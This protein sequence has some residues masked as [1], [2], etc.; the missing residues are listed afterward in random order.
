MQQFRPEYPRPELKRDNWL[1]LNG[2]WQFEIDYCCNGVTTDNVDLWRKDEN[3]F[4][5]I[6]SRDLNSK[7][8]VPFCPES[9]LSGVQHTDFFGACWYKN[10][11]KIPADWTGRILLHFEASFYNTIVSVNGTIVGSHA[12]GYTPFSFDITDCIKDGVAD[13]VVHCSGDARNPKQPS[14]KQSAVRSSFGCFYTRSTGI[15]QT[16][17]LENVPE[18]YLKK[19]KFTPDIDNSQLHVE[20]D[21][22]KSGKKSVELA[23][24]FAG[25]PVVSK[26]VV[27]DGVRGMAC[28]DIKDAKLWSVDEPNL[29]DLEIKTIA[30]GVVDKVDTY[31]GMR[32]VTWSDGEMRINGKKVFQRLVLDQGYY[33]DG[34]YTA[35]TLDDLK[36]DIEISQ[37]VG[38]NGARLHQKVFERNFLYFADKMGYI[39]W[40]EYAS[41]GFDYTKEENTNDYI[42]E[43]LESVDRDYNHPAIIGWIPMNENWEIKKNFQSNSLVK[44]VYEA[45]KVAD[46]TR[47]VIDA[48]WN[49]HVVTDVFDTHDYDQN[50]VTFEEHYGKFNDGEGY[51]QFKQKYEGQPYFLSEYGGFTYSPS[52]DGWGYGDAPKTSEEYVARYV[53]MSDVLH[54]N[55]RVCALCYTQLYDVEQEQNGVYTYDRGVKFSKEEMDALK[56]AMSA[57]AKYEEE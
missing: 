8:N 3:F 23:V 33:R 11:V 49:Y 37:G 20:F 35:P 39:V 19:V 45:T 16:V 54:N 13:I 43:W 6:H 38:F 1:N 36:K 57:P 56:K 9:K 27:V 47:P 51:D 28:I 52:G 5:E 34:I 41:W 32:K 2:E 26:T 50:V 4:S 48:S 10:T 55:P 22:N 24:S 17:W 46:P 31:F 29:Y 53:K 7:I 40:G 25:K 15:W 18:T 21:Y 30:D 44:A 14:G 42:R 12:G